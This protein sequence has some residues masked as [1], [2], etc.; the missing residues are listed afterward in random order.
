MIG[1]CLQAVMIWL[2]LAAPALAAVTGAD[3]DGY[4]LW[5]RYRPLSAAQSSQYAPHLRAILAPGSDPSIGKAADELR[6]ALPAMLGAAPLEGQI[7]AGSLLLGT[8]GTA[9]QIAALNLPLR[10]L[11][12]D[13][14]LIRSLRVNGAPVTVIAANQ[15][16]G[17]LYGTFHLLRLVQTG[18]PIDRLD[19]REK[20]KV[21]LR[22]LNHWDNLDRTVERGYSGQS[23]WDW[24][25]LPGVTDRRYEDYARANVSVGINGTVLNN[26]NAKAE[27]LTAPFIAK[28]AAV[29]DVLRPY[30]IR[31]YLSARFSAPRDIGGLSTADP[32]D[33]AV[34]RGGLEKARE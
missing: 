7:R 2:A 28:A 13:G 15:G 22:L 19:V 11:G 5:M 17:V 10:D 23:I 30:G 24:W 9:P 20:P 14:Y 33:P 12:R 3:E 29:A 18:A 1:R 26:V 34:A 16:V 6:R 21:E 32:L 25:R 27:S 4:D 31:V 8:P